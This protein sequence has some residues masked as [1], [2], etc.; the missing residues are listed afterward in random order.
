MPRKLPMTAPGIAASAT[1]NVRASI[2]QVL[3]RIAKI[4]AHL[5][6]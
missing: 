1:S 5:Y 2:L 3:R 6:M 4:M